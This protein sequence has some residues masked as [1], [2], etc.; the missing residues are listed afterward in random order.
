[1]DEKRKVAI[2]IF[3]TFLAGMTATRLMSQATSQY[4]VGGVNIV[5]VTKMD[6]DY[7]RTVLGMVPGVVYDK[8]SL[9]DG[10]ET[11]R[12]IY[13]T[14]GYLNFTA[15]PTENIDEQRKVVDLTIK[16]DEDRQFL[17]KRVTF[18][19]ATKAH[20]ER[21]RRELLIKEGQVFNTLLWELS[22][23][24][25]NQLG[26]FEQIQSQ[27]VQIKPSATEPALDIN[28]TVKEKKRK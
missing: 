2:L 5:G 10:L 22:L 6:P 27:D 8:S 18:T 17:V 21:M 20:E 26:Y 15:V 11:L 24:H 16:I 14:R 23:L 1:M 9:R 7:I 28:V 25:I 12:K 3:G 4:V 19:G 13:G